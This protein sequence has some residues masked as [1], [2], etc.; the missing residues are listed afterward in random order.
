MLQLNSEE[1]HW[2]LSNKSFPHPTILIFG[3]LGLVTFGIVELHFILGVVWEAHHIILP[4]HVW[5]R[6]VQKKEGGRE[7]WINLLSGTFRSKEHLL[8]TPIQNIRFIVSLRQSLMREN[9]G[10]KREKV[11][12]SKN[13][14]IFSECLSRNI[15]PLCF[16]SSKSPWVPLE[17]QST[18]SWLLLICLPVDLSSTPPCMDGSPTWYCRKVKYV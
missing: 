12:Q 14:K 15:S 13:T 1:N 7:E 6:G 2:E 18:S 5:M 11:K 17:L 16:W 10:N 8:P 3:V 9:H 4:S